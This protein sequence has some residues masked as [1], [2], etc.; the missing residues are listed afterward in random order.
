LLTE[1]TTVD[2]A[3]FIKEKGIWKVDC[4]YTGE[5]PNKK[6]TYY[7]RCLIAADG[8]PSKLGRQLGIITEEPQGTCSRAYVKNND[9]F[10]FDGVIFYPPKLLPGY[11]AIF[12]EAKGELNFCTYI[13]PGGPCT[14]DDLSKMH[15]EIMKEYPFVA[16]SLGPNPDIE[17]MKSASLRLGGIAKSY[18]DHLLIIGDAAG[19]IDPLTGEGI[20]YALESG[21]IAAQVLLEAFKK[22]DLS[23]QFLKKYQQ[24]WYAS[25]G[26]E[27]YWSMKMSLF[28]YRFPIMLDA[29]AKLIEKRGTRFLAEWAEVMTGSQSKT[30][31]LRL[32]V[33]PFIMLEVFAQLF[34]NLTGKK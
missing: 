1:N 8:A 10:K 12:R 3:F 34:R 25:W 11:C 30:W 26:R 18:D 17:R 9:L 2:N 7:A 20:Q 24:M 22:Q 14:N 5:E 23:A 13:I 19:F 27:F 6:V 15:H 29:A 32:D 21:E 16:K 28:L 31:F 4:T 33:W